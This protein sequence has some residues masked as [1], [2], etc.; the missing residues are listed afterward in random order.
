MGIKDTKIGRTVRL[1]PEVNQR[2]LDL[3]AHLGINPNAYL[4]GEI[5]KAIAR[6]ELSFNA[7]QQTDEMFSN[8]RALVSEVQDGD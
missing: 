3:C 7:K 5:G 1:T 8:L 4:V 2:L 6:D